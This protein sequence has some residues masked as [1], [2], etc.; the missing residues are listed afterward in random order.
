MVRIIQSGGTEYEETNPTEH[1]AIGYEEKPSV[2]KPNV[3]DV[4]KIFRDFMVAIMKMQNRSP[5]N[6]KV[7]KLQDEVHAK[8]DA[9]G[10]GQHIDWTPRMPEKDRPVPPQH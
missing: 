6:P 5:E 9:I 1:K 7:R 8:L 4:Y 2:P 3:E 10:I